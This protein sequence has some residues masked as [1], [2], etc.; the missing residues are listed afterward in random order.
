[1]TSIENLILVASEEASE[2]S[3]ALDKLLRFGPK[4]YDPKYPEE[5]NEHQVMKEFLHLVEMVDILKDQEVL[6]NLPLLEDHEIRKAKREAVFH[7]VDISREIGT[8]TD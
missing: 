5:T 7:H 3:Q 6:H 8:V 4:G 1:M 2:L